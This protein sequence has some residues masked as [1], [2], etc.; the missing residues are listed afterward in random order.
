MSRI[1]SRNQVR[2]YPD[3]DGPY[4]TIIIA[5]HWNDES[6]V[7]LEIRESKYTFVANDLIMAIKNAQNCH[8]Y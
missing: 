5:N 8:R 2:E 6:K 1:E 7:V 4:T 3:K